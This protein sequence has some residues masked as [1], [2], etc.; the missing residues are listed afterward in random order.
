MHMCSFVISTID[1][2]PKGCDDHGRHSCR[3][4][5]RNFSSVEGEVE[6]HLKALING[7][8]AGEATWAVGLMSSY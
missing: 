3:L 1:V 6:I 4:C 2:L 5:S 7:Q 8:I